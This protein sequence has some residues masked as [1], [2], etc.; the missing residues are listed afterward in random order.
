MKIEVVRVVVH[1]NVFRESLKHLVVRI[2]IILHDNTR[3]HTAAAATD[4]LRH[5]Q[6]EIREHQP[7]SPDTSPCD[8]DLFAKVKEPLRGAR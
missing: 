6:W 8:Y 1:Y 3:D 2:L 4:L 5:W 7:Y